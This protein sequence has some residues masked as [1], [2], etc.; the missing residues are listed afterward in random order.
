MRLQLD[1]NTAT[2]ADDQYATP[3]MGVGANAAVRRS[4]PD[5]SWE[6]GFDL[7]DFQGTSHDR[8]YAL[9]K[10]TG[11]RSGGGGQ[12]MGGIY[13]EGARRLGPWLLTGGLRLDGWWD[14]ASRLVQS[15]QT[16]LDLRDP[17]R[18]GLTPTFRLGARRD[19]HSGLY[20][21]AAG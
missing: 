1:R 5:Y 21:R 7:R 14:Y 3:A 18:R 17:D 16:S 12:M 20:L 4:A 10:P 19:Y 13:A 2:L 8:L 6:L 9:G 15:G 11:T